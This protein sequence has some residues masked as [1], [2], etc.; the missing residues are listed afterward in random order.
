MTELERIRLLYDLACEVVDESC[1]VEGEPSVQFQRVLDEQ[2]QSERR[3]LT[4]AAIPPKA[5]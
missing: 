1:A 4:E 3:I 2:R 5:A